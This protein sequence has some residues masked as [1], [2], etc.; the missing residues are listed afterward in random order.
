MYPSGKNLLEQPILSIKEHQD[1]QCSSGIQIVLESV[2]V[3]LARGRNT[4]SLGDLECTAPNSMDIHLF[5]K[6]ICKVS[7]FDSRRT[8]CIAGVR[9]APRE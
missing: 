5:N 2:K 8:P 4:G 6:F 7:Q 9:Q 3:K 1:C